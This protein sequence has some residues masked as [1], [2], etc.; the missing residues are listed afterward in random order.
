MHMNENEW[1][2]IYILGDEAT[3]WTDV[4][5]NHFFVGRY[6]TIGSCTFSHFLQVQ[7]TDAI[8]INANTVTYFTINIGLSHLDYM[9]F[10][11]KCSPNQIH[12]QHFIHWNNTNSF[13]AL[14]LLLLSFV[15]KKKIKH[16]Y[17]PYNKMIAFTV[18]IQYASFNT[19]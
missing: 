2:A 11:T 6:Y 17:T 12:L 18:L 16:I 5:V 1:V 4:W 7:L 19:L 14:F 9:S 8:I 10:S 15:S 13:Y 3:V